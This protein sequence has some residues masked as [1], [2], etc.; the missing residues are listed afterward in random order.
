MKEMDMQKFMKYFYLMATVLFSGGLIANIANAY[1]FTWKV[2]NVYARVNW[3]C[4]SLVFNIMLIVMMALMYNTEVKKAKEMLD[5][6]IPE[7]DLKA[8]KEKFAKADN[9]CDK[10]CKEV[11]E[12]GKN[13]Q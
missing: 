8:L 1:F 6:T 13:R 11:N 10:V 12:D 3:I 4:V 7:Q 9:V 5:I 2:M